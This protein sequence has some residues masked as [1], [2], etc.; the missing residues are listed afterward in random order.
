M[1]ASKYLTIDSFTLDL[2]TELL[3]FQECLA[4]LEHLVKNHGSRILSHLNDQSH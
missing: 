1:I 3:A 2:S 4:W